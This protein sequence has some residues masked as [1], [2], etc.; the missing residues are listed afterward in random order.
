M[1]V[2][3]RVTTVNRTGW[4]TVA[5]IRVFVLPDQVMGSPLNESVVLTGAAA[6]PYESRGTLDD[7]RDGIGR[8][9]ASQSRL[10]LAVSASLAGPL[11]GLIGAEGGG[12][13]LYG[14]S[15]RGKTTTLKAAA[16]VWGRGAADPGF[17]RS[18]RATA[19][20]QE[21]TAAIVTDTVLCLDE[22]G[23]AE[24]RDAAAA[25]YQL[26]SG[27]GKTRS[28][29]DGYARTPM[30]WRVLTLST[31]EMPMAV[32]IAEDKQRR[33]YAGQAVRLL[34]IPAD[35]GR[36]FGVFD[37]TSGFDD[38]GQLAEAIQHAAVT[39]FGTAGPLLSGSSP[40]G[41]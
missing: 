37:N 30:T 38:P 40:I 25:V 27:V 16:S 22:I 20:A 31:G 18:W 36:G 10:V 9:V 6:A 34:D 32:K 19:N 1:N 35:A 2:R 29:R 26:A 39:A 24:G 33:A 3:H 5:G 12:L 11:L 4:H 8:L 23:V 28:T 15:S 7:W 14:T 41:T 21:A 13:N 17:V